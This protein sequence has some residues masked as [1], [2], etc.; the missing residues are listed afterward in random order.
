MTFWKLF[1]K[2]QMRSMTSEEQVM[3]DHMSEEENDDDY[4][5]VTSLSEELSNSW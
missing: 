2:S 5:D 4:V 1:Y 3:S